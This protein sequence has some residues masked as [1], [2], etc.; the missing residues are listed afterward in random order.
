[1]KLQLLAERY[2]REVWPVVTK[3]LKE[4]G[5]G[6]ELNLVSSASC[7]RCC[8]DPDFVSCTL[9]PLFSLQIGRAMCT[10]GQHNVPDSMIGGK[11][12]LLSIMPRK[13]T[14]TMQVEGSMTVKTTRKTWDPFIIIKARDLLKLL[15]RSV[16]AAQVIPHKH[17]V[18]CIL[19]TACLSSTALARLSQK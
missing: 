2:L 18:S 3:A 14:L 9:Q 17:L 11:Y 6:C 15:A 8:F 4:V 13:G 10:A 19:Q 16:P 1:M 5:I 12:T 7:N